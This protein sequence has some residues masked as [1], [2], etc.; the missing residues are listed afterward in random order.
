MRLH[1]FTGGRCH[2]KM[3]SDFQVTSWQEC[4]LMERPIADKKTGPREFPILPYELKT[5]KLKLK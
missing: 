1:E 3:G 4:D 2:V 5:F